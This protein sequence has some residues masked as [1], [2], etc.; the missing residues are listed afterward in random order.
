MTFDPAPSVKVLGENRTE[1]FRL[2]TLIVPTSVV[3]TLPAG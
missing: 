2:P 1:Y 3:E